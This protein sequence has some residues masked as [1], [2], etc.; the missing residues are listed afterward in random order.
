M[1]EPLPALS[2]SR[3]LDLQIAGNLRN[4]AKKSHTITYFPYRWMQAYGIRTDA[5]VE[6]IRQRIINRLALKERQAR[7]ARR[8]AG[9]SVLGSEAL[10]RQPIMK[11]HTPKKRERKIFIYTTINQLRIAYIQEMRAFCQLCRECYLALKAGNPFPPWPP[12]AIRPYMPP[13]ATAI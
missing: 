7:E 2:L 9:R 4:S 5:E 3:R 10:C 8:R 11:D 12:G 13:L 6:A 1:I